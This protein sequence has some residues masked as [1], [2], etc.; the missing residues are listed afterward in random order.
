MTETKDNIELNDDMDPRFENLAAYALGALDDEE[1]RAAVEHLIEQFP[2]V[3]A[4][5]EELSEA[6]DYLAASVTPVEP[7]AH[8]KANILKQAEKESAPS[9]ARLV[10]AEIAS[11][12]SNSA[13]WWQRVFQSGYAVSAAAAMLVI[14]VGSVLSYQN[15]QLGNEIDSLRSDLA[16]ETV[17]VANLQNELAT[18]LN[19][20]ESRVAS[21]KSEMEVME[22]EFGATTEMVNH[23][24]EMVSELAVANDAL[25]QALRDQSWL[26]YV[27]MK[28]GYQVESWLA[29][30]TQQVATA[31]PDAAGLIAVR[32]VGNEAVFQVH[33]LP[34]PQPDHA[35][36]LW[37]MGNGD[38]TPVSQFEVSEI[39]A[40]TVAFLL[41]APLK[42]Y[43]SVMVTQERVNGIGNDPSGTMVIFGETN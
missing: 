21:M 6:T 43:S 32:V 33:G 42:F 26:T 12:R 40:A 36:T 5:Y 20:S 39:G 2:E 31:D 29:N 17:L 37:L 13:P 19:D 7:P 27:A 10:A 15:T 1:S 9:V 4:E 11:N 23:Q 8:L 14:V 22:D 28:E 18:T 30:D 24:E 3:R 16:A 35:Y 38:P 41:P 25:R 34:Q